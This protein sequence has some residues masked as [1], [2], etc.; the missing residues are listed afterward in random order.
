MSRQLAVDSALLCATQRTNGGKNNNL[1]RRWSAH[2][3][4]R[5]GGSRKKD[6]MPPCIQD[7]SAM[8]IEH[9]QERR[10][11]EQH[12]KR[13]TNSYMNPGSVA[14]STTFGATQTL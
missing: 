3:R 10:D 12:A 6:Q 2:A 11:G 14:R 7:T 13:P 8:R 5:K 9:N 4:G 1:I